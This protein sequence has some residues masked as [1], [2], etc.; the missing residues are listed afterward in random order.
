MCTLPHLSHPPHDFLIAF[1][2][3]QK[4]HADVTFVVGDSKEV[5]RCHKAILCARS[6]YFLAMFRVGGMS[7][8][9]KNEIEVKGH[10]KE[11]FDRMTEYIYTNGVSGLDSCSSQV[12]QLQGLMFLVSN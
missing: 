5:V 2:V 9:T 12:V 7:E 4:I 11:T 10:D 8:S 3:L 1:A 6:E